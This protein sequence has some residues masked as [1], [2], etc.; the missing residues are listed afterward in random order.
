MQP[1]PPVSLSS[2]YLQRAVRRA[3]S[4]AHHTEPRAPPGHLISATLVPTATCRLVILIIFF[5]SVL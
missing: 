1:G 5:P 4:A 2:V 3:L